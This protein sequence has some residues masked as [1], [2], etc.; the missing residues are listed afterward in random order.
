MLSW[1]SGFLSADQIVL[2][3]CCAFSWSLSAL[4]FNNQLVS[5]RSQTCKNL[6]GFTEIGCPCSFF[7]GGSDCFGSVLCIGW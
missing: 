7:A 6:A 1:S 2:V 4:V 5:Q 3:P